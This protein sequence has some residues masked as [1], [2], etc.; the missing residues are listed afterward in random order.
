MQ[1]E[2]SPRSF[3]SRPRFRQRRRAKAGSPEKPVSSCHVRRWRKRRRRGACSIGRTKNSR[4]TSKLQPDFRFCT[5]SSV[6]RI[7][8]R[9]VQIISERSGHK[10]GEID[11][12]YRSDIEHKKR[13]KRAKKISQ[14]T[15]EMR[16]VKGQKLSDIPL[17]ASLARDLLI[18]DLPKV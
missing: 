2:T 8:C 17:S 5:D 12:E 16:T 11:R 15:F 18:I 4:A 13:R 7:L 14:V 1:S 6:Q 10:T 3:P 9:C